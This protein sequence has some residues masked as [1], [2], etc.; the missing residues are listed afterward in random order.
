MLPD[1]SVL[2]CGVDVSGVSGVCCGLMRLLLYLVLW[3]MVRRYMRGEGMGRIPFPF[4][5][6]RACRYG[7]FW[8]AHG[9]R[10]KTHE[11]FVDHQG[12]FTR[13]GHRFHG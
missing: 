5:L 11:C 4:I 8:V 10:E 1:M 2:W 12:R 7:G 3:L 13:C 9:R 6:V